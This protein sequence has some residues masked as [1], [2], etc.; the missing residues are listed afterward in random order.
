[1]D[2]DPPAETGPDDP[3]C[4]S[5]AVTE[6]DLPVLAIFERELARAGF[7]E[8]PILDLGYHQ[9]KLRRALRQ[10]PEGM[11]VQMVRGEIAA[12]LWLS[13]KRTLATGERYGVVR[14]LYVREGYRGHGL[15][16]G[17]ADYALRYFAARGVAK[18]LAKAHA[19]NRPALQVLRRAG[20]TPLHLTL[21]YR[22]EPG[23][24]YLVE[25]TDA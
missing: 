21:Q 6:Q 17:L 25:E 11:I 23:S 15:A 10:E 3:E 9:E 1:M 18:I 22:L 20:F 24:P 16:L 8:D 19:E 7:P 4:I 5:R 12:W 2:R 13:T 14:S